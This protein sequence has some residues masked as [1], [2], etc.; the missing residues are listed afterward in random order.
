VR[1]QLPQQGAFPIL[2]FR[3][4]A[5]EQTGII[6]ATPNA[7]IRKL[8]VRNAAAAGLLNVD[9]ESRLVAA[10]PLAAKP[11]DRSFDLRLQ[12]N[13]ARYEWPINGV[14]FDTAKPRGQAAQ[15]RVKKGQRVAVKFINETG[16]SHPMHLHGHSFQVIEIN[17]KR[18]NGALRDTILV[19]PKMSVTVAFEANNPGTWY[20]HCHILWHLAA[21]MATLV[22]YET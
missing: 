11:I 15:V 21:G 17:G 19:P 16:M 14:I 5:T 9:L 22:Q 13:M 12:G 4:G 7:S 10:E 8:P 1:V 6:L 3:E 2:A 20:L 18:Q